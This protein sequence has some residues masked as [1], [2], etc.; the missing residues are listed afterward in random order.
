M[1]SSKCPICGGRV[2]EKEVEKVIKGGKDAVLLKVKAGV[3][4]KCGER[5]YDKTTHEEIQ[6]LRENLRKGIT[7][8]LHP[9]GHTYVTR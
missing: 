8:R 4:I 6:H 1:I 5:L 7:T 2:V 9:V 3:C